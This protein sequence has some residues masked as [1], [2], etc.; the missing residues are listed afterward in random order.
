[1]FTANYTFLLFTML[2]R[3]LYEPTEL[4]VWHYESL[5]LPLGLWAIAALTMNAG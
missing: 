1:M 2:L 4:Y 3:V 5:T